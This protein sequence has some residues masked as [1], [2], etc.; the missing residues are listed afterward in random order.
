MGDNTEKQPLI[1][2][3]HGIKDSFLSPSTMSPEG[4]G[5]PIKNPIGIKAK[6]IMR[7]FTGIGN[8]VMRLVIGEISILYATAIKDK[9]IRTEGVLK[10]RNL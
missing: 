9:A 4:K 8:G 6:N 1:A 2:H 10:S 5:I 7:I 3:A